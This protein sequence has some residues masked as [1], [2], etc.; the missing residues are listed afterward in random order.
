[1]NSGKSLS[2]AAEK[3]EEIPEREELKNWNR[4][5]KNDHYEILN[6]EQDQNRARAAA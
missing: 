6:H 5:K 2:D 4:K 1:M 3:S